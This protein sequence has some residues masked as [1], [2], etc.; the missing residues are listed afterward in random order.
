MLSNKKLSSKVYFN[1]IRIRMIEME[2][3][4]KYKEQKMRCPVH[5][6]VGQEFLP[7]IIQTFFN[8]NDKAV[9]GHRAHAHYLS[10]N[11][12]LKKLIAEIYGKKSGCSGGIG[13]SMHLIDTSKGFIGSTAIVGNTIPIGAGISLSMSLKKN[14]RNLTYIFFG[15]GAVETG[16]FYETL[17]FVALK[18][19]PCLFICENNYF[20]VYSEF[21]KR[22][23][24]NRKIF[25]LASSFGIKSD[26][27]NTKN[28]DLTYQKFSKAYNYV[29]S[30]Q[31]P[32]FIEF[33]TS[34]KLEHCGPDEDDHLNYRKKK[35]LDFWKKNDPVNK[36]EKTLMRKKILS[37]KQ[38][39]SMKVKIKKE[40]YESFNFAKKS[41][42]PSLDDLKKNLF[43]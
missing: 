17:N 41:K 28:L 8:K 26:Y 34:R 42:A 14:N 37:I 12:S 43:S 31:K 6:S 29:K 7:A 2:I 13:G 1:S 27:V 38:I 35:F 21:E 20:S 10:K 23:P 11:C 33:Q 22:Q 9:S 30:K 18:N 25:K 16:V 32:F 5:L 19:L 24:K 39:E 36:L 15:D 40:I 4:K 3:S